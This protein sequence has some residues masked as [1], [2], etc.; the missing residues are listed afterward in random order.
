MFAIHSLEKEGLKGCV[1]NSDRVRVESE[2]GETRSLERTELCSQAQRPHLLWP[3][4]SAVVPI[5]TNRPSW[6]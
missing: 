3:S 5:A 4:N 2:S 1:R 6:V